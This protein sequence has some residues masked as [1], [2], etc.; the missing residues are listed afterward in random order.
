MKRN[1]FH[2]I[3]K[4]F[5]SMF[6]C[7]MF[8]LNEWWRGPKQKCVFCFDVHFRKNQKIKPIFMHDDD[9]KKKCILEWEKYK[10]K[11]QEKKWNE[12]K[13]IEVNTSIDQLKLWTMSGNG[14]CINLLKRSNH[15]KQNKC[16]FNMKIIS[17]K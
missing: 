10:K 6:S 8:S 12:I 14:D 1:K 4:E 16:Q 5:Y 13:I 2:S 17:N 11:K 15:G 7:L 9:R 3:S